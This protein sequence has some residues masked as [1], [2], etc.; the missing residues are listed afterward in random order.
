MCRVEN[1]YFMLKRD[2]GDKRFAFIFYKP[3]KNKKNKSQTGIPEIVKATG[4]VTATDASAVN[5]ELESSSK[6][7]GGKGSSYNTSLFSCYRGIGKICMQQQNLSCNCSLQ[8]KVPTI[9]F[10]TYMY[11]QMESYVQ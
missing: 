10:F 11:Q 4:N 3:K 5:A 8:I 2:Y 6:E 9:H 7:K 1:T